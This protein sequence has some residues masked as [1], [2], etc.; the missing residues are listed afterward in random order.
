M[1]APRDAE[2]GG[3]HVGLG[4]VAEAAGG[5]EI[6]LFI[7]AAPRQ[8]HEM[9]QRRASSAFA[10]AAHGEAAPAASAVLGGEQPVAQRGAG[11]RLIRTGGMRMRS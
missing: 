10:I 8:R 9:I 5:G 4:G 3:I 11:H 7:R 6:G 2:G 1:I